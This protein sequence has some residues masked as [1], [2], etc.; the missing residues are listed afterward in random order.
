MADV[1]GATRPE[2]APASPTSLLGTRTREVFEAD[3]TSASSASADDSPPAQRPR[4]IEGDEGQLD[5]GGKP[6]PFPEAFLGDCQPCLYNGHQFP[7]QKCW[8][9]YCASGQTGGCRAVICTEH[10]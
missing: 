9:I 4:T 7:V 1:D 6:R 2:P 3:A 10:G 5:A 8:L